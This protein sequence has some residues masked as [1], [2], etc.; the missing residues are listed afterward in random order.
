MKGKIFTLLVGACFMLAGPLLAKGPSTKRSLS[1]SAVSTTRTLSNISNWAYWMYSD[2]TSGIDPTANWGGIYP[3]G[4][5]GNIYQDG[6]VFGGLV[7]GAGDP[8]RVGGATYATG[9]TPGWVNGRGDA[10]SA[11]DANDPR[12]RMYRIRSDW[13][14]L[15]PSQ[16]RDEAA[17]ANLLA[18]GSVSSSQVQE[19]IDQYAIDWKEW[20][21]DLGAP[22]VDVNGNGFYDPVLD[23]NGAAD[24]TA[25][26]YPG[27]ANADQV[28]WQAVNDFNNAISLDLYGTPSMGVELQITAWAYDQDNAKLGQIIFKKYKLVNRSTNTIEKMY[29]GQW[30][31]A[32][33]GGAGDDLTGCDPELSV[34]Y[35]YNGGPVDAQYASFN[36]N[37]TVVGYDFF[38]GPLV[39]T[40]VP[41]D[42]AVFDLQQVTGYK[43]LPMTSFGWFAAGATTITDPP[44]HQKEGATAWYNLLRGFIPTQNTITDSIP[45][46][47]GNIPVSAGGVPTKF[48]LAGNPVN[49]SGDIDG[50]VN[51]TF[52]PGDRRFVLCS[53]PFDLQPWDDANGDG[54]PGFGDAGV[55]EVVVAIIGG[56]GSDYLTNIDIMKDV[57]KVAQDIYNDLFR[58]I[59]KPPPS[60]VVKAIPNRNSIALEWGSDLASVQRTEADNEATGYSFEAYNVYQL[61]SPTSGRDEA[62]RIAT[63]DV[64]NGVT[65]VSQ[66]GTFVPS[67]GDTGTV[68]VQ[69]GTDSGIQR[70]ITIERN[71]LTGDPIYPGNTYYFAVTAYNHNPDPQLIEAKTLESSFI[72]VDGGVT[73]QD[74]RPGQTF[75]A[76]SSS[77]LDIDL[78]NVASD[79]QVEALV[80][81]PTALVD[82]TYS[83]TFEDVTDT[84][85]ANFGAT[86]WNLELDGSKV[87]SNQLQLGSLTDA[88]DQAIVN[89]IKVKVA[90]P[91]VGINVLR[92]DGG[93]GWTDGDRWITGVNAGGD[94]FFSGLFN[95]P[96]F[97]GSS[98]TSGTDYSDVELRFS[99]DTQAN[100]PE[101]WSQGYVYR[102][103]LGYVYDGIGVM[104]FTAWDVETNTQLIV[105]FVEDANDGVANL[106]WDMGWD[107]ATSSYAANGGR[108]YTFITNVPYGN[109]PDA[110]DPFF[111]TS[112]ILNGANTFPVMYAIW[113]DQRGTRPYLHDSFTFQ[114]FASNVNTVDDRFVFNTEA[115][116]YSDAIARADVD[117]ILPY[118]NPYYADNPQEPT[119]LARRITISH[120]PQK[121]EIR[122]F[123][124]AGQQVRV[125][126]KDNEDQFLQWDLLNSS[127][128]PVA[129]GLYIAHVDLPDLGMQKVLKLFIIQKAEILDIF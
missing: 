27:I 118:P 11:A 98:L 86:V 114:I 95:G 2:G 128:L 109:G 129:S 94:A 126:R 37:P 28:V 110:A 24:P 79:G 60:P 31:D 3:R 17:E 105:C 13:A 57:D 8:V 35:A 45:Y 69:S 64:V 115:P 74:P 113:P 44:L 121:A 71:A 103:D 72:V 75:Y 62:V 61:P 15:A 47:E 30:C 1:K 68:V 39:E 108:E 102:R 12:A 124:I 4:T 112:N 122:I 83:I 22:Y 104:P 67:L 34:G 89:G 6:F 82:A 87:L 32:D 65:K 50:G 66:K 40:G 20:P 85:S 91:P 93:W 106:Q 55:Q 127:G 125:L 59:P 123:N 9:L 117:K 49:G 48:P 70:Y 42:T 54:Q 43:N 119:K 76:A 16:V 78:A 88:D 99:G 116:S 41:T 25:G 80:V 10:A 33:V 100:D 101:G 14:T 120:L 107:P 53:G 7:A 36:L 51:N 29:V 26:D 63:F 38:Q 84:S 90:G 92:D 58:S 56:T 46:T 5:M 19:I 111:T 77:L 21:V 96:N 52:A 23:G 97:F 73:A 81:D 18:S